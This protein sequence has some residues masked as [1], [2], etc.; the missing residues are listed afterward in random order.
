MK[1]N[2]KPGNYYVGDPAFVLHTD[3]LRAL[4]IDL[5]KNQ[6]NPGCLPQGYKELV[7]SRRYDVIHGFVC[8]RYWLAF[9]PH[10]QGT[11]YDQLNNGWG[12]DWGVFGCVPYEWIEKKDAYTTHKIHFAAEFECSFT[13][14]SITIGHLH[15]TFNPK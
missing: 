13:E 12:Y 14:D 2:L 5:F 6:T 11:L 4:F 1:F 10:K 8:D 3:D 15:F 9:T 7:V